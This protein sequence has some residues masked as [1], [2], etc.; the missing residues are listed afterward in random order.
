M[1]DV[2]QGHGVVDANENA[3]DVTNAPAMGSATTQLQEGSNETGSLAV[4]SRGYSSLPLV[5]V[6]NPASVFPPGH[7]EEIW[8]IQKGLN[9]PQRVFGEPGRAPTISA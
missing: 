6:G 9:F 4:Y 7:H 8:A 3:G 1:G 2:S 5:A